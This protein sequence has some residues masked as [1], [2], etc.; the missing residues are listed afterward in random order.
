M[1]LLQI[2]YLFFQNVPLVTQSLRV[3]A[4]LHP[5]RRPYSPPPERLPT[6]TDH[7]KWLCTSIQEQL[8]D[9]GITCIYA[10][11][12]CRLVRTQK[13]LGFFNRLFLDPK[14]NNH[15]RLNLK[16]T[17]QISPKT[18]KFKWKHQK[19]S[20]P[21]YRQ[22]NFKDSSTHNPESTCMFMSKVNPTNL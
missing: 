4:S 2:F 5:Q 12:S 14:L 19:V 11:A 15:W 3:G 18:E 22:G 20:G 21:P 16:Y 13:S 8:I 9:R 7:H 6:I 10:K 1:V 17:D